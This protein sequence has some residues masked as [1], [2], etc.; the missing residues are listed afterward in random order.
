MSVDRFEAIRALLVETEEAHG[1]YE[2][3]E[4]NGVYDQDWARWYAAYALEHGIGALLG[5]EVTAEQ[6]AQF[7][8]MSYNELTQTDPKPDEPWPDH[9]ARRI[10]AEL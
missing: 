2:T 5:H 8:A 6:L 1:A 3:T 4:L 10:A 9:T 7:L